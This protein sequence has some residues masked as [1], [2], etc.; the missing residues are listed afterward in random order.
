M[1]ISLIYVLN[2]FSN[3]IIEKHLETPKD[4]EAFF[5]TMELIGVEGR[6]IQQ[7]G[8]TFM[9]IDPGNASHG[10]YVGDFVYIFR[11]SDGAFQ[12]RYRVR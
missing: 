12:G 6:Y 9:Y 1:D 7:Q 5:D 4:L 10:G 2:N 3:R 11:K 8:N